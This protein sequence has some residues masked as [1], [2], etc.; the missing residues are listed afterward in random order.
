MVSS[1]FV[2]VVTTQPRR[3]LKRAPFTPSNKGTTMRACRLKLLPN[4]QSSY[5]GMAA[6]AAGGKHSTFPLWRFMN[7]TVQGSRQYRHMYS[8]MESLDS[9]IPSIAQVF[10]NHATSSYEK[11][12]TARGK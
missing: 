1:V 10:D 2:S 9:T 3:I 7:L 6:E 5:V 4:P 12:G 8:I 11:D